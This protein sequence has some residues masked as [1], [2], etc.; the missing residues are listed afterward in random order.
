MKPQIAAILLLSTFSAYIANAEDLLEYE[1]GGIPETFHP[2]QNGVWI[3]QD[4]VG[5]NGSRGL[6]PLNIDYT[7]NFFRSS[8]RDFSI[9]Q[10]I[11]EI[12]TFF[13]V[14][15]PTSTALGVRT[16]ELGF[17]SSKNPNSFIAPSPS[18][19][20][21]WTLNPSSTTETVDGFSFKQSISSFVYNGTTGAGRGWTNPNS[22]IK[23][24]SGIWYKGIFQVERISDSTIR[25][26][27]YIDDYG[28]TGSAYRSRISS[29]SSGQTIG[30]ETHPYSILAQDST[31][32]PASHGRDSGGLLAIDRTSI[33][34]PI[35][36]NLNAPLEIF[37]A[38]EI[39]W[40][41]EVGKSYYVQRSIDLLD[42][43][44]IE[45]PIVGNGSSMQRLF[46]SRH[47]PRQFYRITT[48]TP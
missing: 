43:N 26:S 9:P 10:A 17:A 29:T 16:M 11:L 42:W 2:S 33:S 47:V 34:G 14:K 8:T 12:S 15:K 25:M 27:A 20:L 32:Y 3:L 41:T 4:G 40:S 24:K 28:A 36:P 19:T 35:T 45:G 44:Y 13:Q 5:L 7:V 31:L 46:S 23:L 21:Y 1:Q 6:T 38:I 30:S 22:I 37:T 39:A 18:S 48:E